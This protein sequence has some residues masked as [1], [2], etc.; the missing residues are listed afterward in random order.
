MTKTR[1]GSQSASGEIWNEPGPSSTPASDL[2]ASAV[3][4]LGLI[5]LLC[6][7]STVG[8]M[9]VG[10]STCSLEIRVRAEVS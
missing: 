10:G 6:L 1:R 8:Q 2:L 3:L 9:E 5:V 4:E 7:S